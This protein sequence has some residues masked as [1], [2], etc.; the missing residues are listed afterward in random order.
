MNRVRVRGGGCGRPAS[1]EPAAWGRERTPPGAHGHGVGA[2]VP[3]LWEHGA[4][5]S[6]AALAPS[7]CKDVC[8]LI[9][10]PSGS[11]KGL[12]RFWETLSHNIC[13]SK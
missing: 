3:L 8:G 5:R 11:G 9:P 4:W 7:W 12:T 13:W 2:W 10:P 1:R 6:F